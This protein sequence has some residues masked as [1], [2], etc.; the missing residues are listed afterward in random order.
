[1]R[2]YEGSMAEICQAL[3]WHLLLEGDEVDTGHWQSLK[4]VPHTK[5]RELFRVCV[6][7]PIPQ[8]PGIAQFMV[9]P[10]L[11]WAEDHFQERVGGVPTNPGSQ[12]MS[13]PWYD[14]N[15]KAQAG[16]DA[17]FS[18]TYQER[19]WP[20]FANVGTIRP[21]GRQ[22]FVPH[23]GVRYEYGDLQ[24]VIN[25]LHREPT[26]R[27]AYL[28]IWFPEDTGAHHGERVPCTLGYHFML[29]GGLLHVTYHI[30]S[31]DFLRYF[32]DDVYM[33]MRLGQWILDQL[34]KIEDNECAAWVQETK[35]HEDSYDRSK[36]P[37]HDVQMG[38]LQMNIGSLHVF[39][40]DMAKMN[41]TAPPK[42]GSGIG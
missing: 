27:Q 2:Y 22:V 36:Q 18:H 17:K 25:L 31:C 6:E 32:R 21:N 34:W 15:W 19:M 11:P 26:T 40:G 29:R 13:W 14:P 7:T 28:P 37:W 38:V 10:N 35:Q 9:E 5:T 8:R 20:K 23:N 1:M 3:H 12:F 33:A 39:E 42:P 16:E 41:R 24:D 4:D 30:R